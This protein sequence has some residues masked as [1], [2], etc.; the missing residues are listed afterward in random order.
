MNPNR[1]AKVSGYK[2]V[3]A[4]AITYLPDFEGYHKDRF[5]V[6]KASLNTMRDNAGEDIGT[7]IWDNGSCPEVIDWL[8]NEYKPD[9]LVISTN[10]GKASARAGIVRAVSPGTILGVA[11]DDIL[12]YPDW[13][14]KSIDILE[15]F[16][17]V[18]QVSGYPV[19]T[20]MRWGNKNT[21]A[22]AFRNA[23][24][25]YGRFIPDEWD[26]DFCT[27]IG[28]DYEWHKAYTIDDIDAMITYKGRQVYAVAHHCQF[29]CYANRLEDIVRWDND[30][31]GDEKPFDWAVDNAGLLRLTTSE[32]LTRHIG[33]KLDEDMKEALCR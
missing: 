20:Q 24:L 18:G 25:E 9:H 4:S 26:R 3:I 30:A 19:R 14:K 32:R 28:R 6:V 13:F 33:N 11:D 23:K 15:S 17:N 12:Y 29:I 7:F 5:E 2:P 8:M 21:K 16:P 10:I 31:M 22:W 1:L 27:S